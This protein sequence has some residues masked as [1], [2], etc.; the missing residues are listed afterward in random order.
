MQPTKCERTFDRWPLGEESVR[1][2]CDCPL[3]LARFLQCHPSLL[4]THSS[5]QQNPS[6]LFRRFETR[7]G[8]LS[9]HIVFV[10]HQILYFDHDF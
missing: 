2:V 9:R 1:A 7:P 10:L 4:T 6:F 3:S 8:S 5:T